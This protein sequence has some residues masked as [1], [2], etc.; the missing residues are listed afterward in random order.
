[1]SSLFSSFVVLLGAFVLHP[2]ITRA[3]QVVHIPAPTWTAANSTTDEQRKLWMPL[4]YQEDQGFNTSSNFTQWQLTNGFKTLRDFMDNGNYSVTSPQQIPDDNIMRTYGY[5]RDGPCEIWLDNT[6]AY[7]SVDCLVS[8]PNMTYTL[9]YSGCG[10]S[11]VMYW[12]TLGVAK[13]DRVY[14]WEVYKEC[15]PLYMNATTTTATGSSSYDD[16]PGTVKPAS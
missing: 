9:D 10:A 5:T 2:A 6:L 8:L 3:N 4:A 15:I 13:P 7:S 16:T 14:S 1:M 12:Y 11:C